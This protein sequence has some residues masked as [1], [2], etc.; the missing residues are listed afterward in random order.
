MASDY[1]TVGSL[2]KSAGASPFGILHLMAHLYG[3][4]I[5]LE[6]AKKAAAPALAEAR[7]NNWMMAVAIVDIAGDLVYFEKMDDTQAGSVT[8]AMAKARAAARFK[9]PTK[10]FQDILTTNSDGLRI[11]G[12][13]GAVPVEG[14]LPLVADG[15]IIGAIGVSGGTSQEDG[16]CAKAGAD[17][18]A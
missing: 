18:V 13:E 12:L 5:R 3:S 15:K 11:L 6:L 4:S 16:V 17:V 7:R 9:R 2:A 14:G 1:R 8:I 10:A